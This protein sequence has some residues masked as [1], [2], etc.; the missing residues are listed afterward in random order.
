MSHKSKFTFLWHHFSS[1]CD[2][3]WILCLQI[4]DIHILVDVIIVDLICV[5]LISRVVFQKIV[6]TITNQVKGVSYC[7]RCL[8]DDF[9]LL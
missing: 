6:V 5:D 4:D 3:E 2:K 7:D 8:E 1:H 9:M